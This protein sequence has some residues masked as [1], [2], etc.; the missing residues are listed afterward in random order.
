VSVTTDKRPGKKKAGAPIV[1]DVLTAEGG[2]APH[3]NGKTP[4]E[5]H[6]FLHALQAMRAGDFSVRM[7][8]D[9]EGLAG[10]IAE[11]FN[12]IVTANERMAKELERVG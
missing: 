5:L 6:E 1:T 8:A 3:Q 9:H 11:T 10:K 7:S 4:N 2:P 12:E